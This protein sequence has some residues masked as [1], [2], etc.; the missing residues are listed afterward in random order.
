MTAEAG[1][2]ASVNRLRELCW[3]LDTSAIMEIAQH[4]RRRTI[5]REGTAMV[6]SRASEG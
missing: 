3:V 4:H 1:K 6:Y 5:S 2:V